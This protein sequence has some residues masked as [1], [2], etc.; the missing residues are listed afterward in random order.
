ML[1][2]PV[3]RRSV[4]THSKKLKRH[5]REQR[6][7]ELLRPRHVEDLLGELVKLVVPL[8]RHDDDVTLT[9]DDDLD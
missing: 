6:R 7:E 9:G 5:D 8:F 1:A 4:S 3:V 2:C